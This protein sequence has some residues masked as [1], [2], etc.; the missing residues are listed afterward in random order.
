MKKLLLV[1]LVPVLVLG[2]MGCAKVKDI[3]D[4]VP[5]VL[6]GTWESTTPALSLIV[7]GS[8]ISLWRDTTDPNDKVLF[9]TSFSGDADDETGFL[10]NEEFTIT[11][12]EFDK[13][14]EEIGTLECT[15][16]AAGAV[17]AKV[18]LDNITY[19]N[20]R[21]NYTETLLNIFK[22]AKTFSVNQ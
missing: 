20:D 22:N 7:A 1:M 4:P 12:Y 9:R 19:P 21:S 3:G 10:N 15:A 5:T 14:W 16:D 2:V 13:K 18:T 11:F 17:V 6:Q 8:Q